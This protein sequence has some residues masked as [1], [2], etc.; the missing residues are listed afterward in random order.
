MLK[1]IIFDLDGTLADTSSDIISSVNY[2]LKKKK[3]K[4]KINFNFFK[5]VA[6]NGSVD[7]FIK[8]LPKKNNKFIIEIN[9][10][11]I[12]HYQNNI[13]IK[14][15]LKKNLIFFL[16]LCKKKKIKLFISKNKKR[17]IAKL[18][19]KKLKINNYFNFIAG[20][21][22]FRHRK[23]SPLHLV[24]LSKKFNLNKREILYI[25]DTEIDSLMAR[26]FKIHFVLIKNGYTTLSYNR[27]SHDILTSDYKQLYKD[28]K[29]IRLI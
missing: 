27:I 2:S 26:K 24:A 14:S 5:K 3:I 18:L 15:K 17:K 20:S 12:N 1:N 25:G 19:I 11:F 6:N 8:L 21:D 13:C 22:T 9:N 4:K 28:L 10:I 23:P 7:M 29:K 16:K